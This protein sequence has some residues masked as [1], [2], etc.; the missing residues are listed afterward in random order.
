M[1]VTKT[2]VRRRRLEPDHASEVR[3]ALCGN[4]VVDVRV[5][6]SADGRGAWDILLSSGD[7]LTFST[8]TT[9]SGEFGALPL[10]SLADDG[11]TVDRRPA[12]DHVH[13]CAEAAPCR[14]TLPTGAL[15]PGEAG[16]Q[17]LRTERGLLLAALHRAAALILASGQFRSGEAEWLTVGTD[18]AAL[19]RRLRGEEERA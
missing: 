17:R 13:Y 14:G 16:D 8:P 18:A 1:R 2:K 3:S 19:V 4:R 7:R 15:G 9:D 10:L 5:R 11:R 6:K 12:P